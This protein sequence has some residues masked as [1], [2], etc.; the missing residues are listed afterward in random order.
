[1]SPVGINTP[2]TPQALAPS[3]ARAP[4]SRHAAKQRDDL[5]AFESIELH[6]LLQT[7]DRQG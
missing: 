4:S 1:M 6:P 7:M 2:I 3:Y 5:A